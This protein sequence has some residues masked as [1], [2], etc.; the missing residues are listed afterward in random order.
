[1]FVNEYGA[2]SKALGNTLAYFAKKGLITLSPLKRLLLAKP[3]KTV[4]KTNLN[5]LTKLT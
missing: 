1:M 2:S 4:K 5:Y 3:D